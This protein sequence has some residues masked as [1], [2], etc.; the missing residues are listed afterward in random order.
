MPSPRYDGKTIDLSEGWQGAH[1]CSV[2]STAEVRCFDTEQEMRDALVAAARI[3]PAVPTDQVAPASPAAAA[4][5]CVT[6]YAD[7]SMGGNSLSFVSTSGWVNLAPYGFDNDMESWV[8][9]TPCAGSRRR[10]DRRQQCA[11][12]ARGSQLLE[13]RRYELEEPGV[14]DQRLAV[15]ILFAN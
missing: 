10:R 15:R 3:A 13:Q 6:L 8:N 9:Q 1:A 2:V 11:A 12:V 4:E 14:V 7:I 5:T